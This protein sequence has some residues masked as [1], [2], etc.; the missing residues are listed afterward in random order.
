M[1]IIKN[2]SDKDKIEWMLWVHY[3][4]LINKMIWKRFSKDSKE[5]WNFIKK[6][7]KYNLFEKRDG[8]IANVVKDKC[9]QIIVDKDKV[10]RLILDN[11]EIIH[12]K[13]NIS[14][15]LPSVNKP[16]KEEAKAMSLKINPNK[17]ITLDIV[18]HS[19]LKTHKKMCRGVIL[20][21]L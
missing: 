9:N 1:E 21:K 2:Q 11:F 17:A 20:W 8:G 7:C 6:F 3:K 19:L 18:P 15:N 13:S 14:T 5:A 12:G 10:D 4:E 16:S